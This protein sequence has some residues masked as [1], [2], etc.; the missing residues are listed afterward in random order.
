LSVEQLADVARIGPRQ[1][2]RQFAVETGET[3]ARTVERLRCEAALPQIEDTSEPLD[4]IALQVGFGDI[5]RMRRVCP[6]IY[7]QP[8]QALRRK[9]RAQGT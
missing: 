2:A 5:E 8:P 7:G 3:P 1:C 4:Q 9:S 6:R